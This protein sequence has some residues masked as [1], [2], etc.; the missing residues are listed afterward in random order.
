MLSVASSFLNLVLLLLGRSGAPFPRCCSGARYVGVPFSRCRS[1]A[2][3][4]MGLFLSGALMHD[5]ERLVLIDALI[6][7]LICLGFSALTHKAL[8]ARY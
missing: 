1:Y 5:R 6:H 7:D 2:R 3:Y 8:I 4:M